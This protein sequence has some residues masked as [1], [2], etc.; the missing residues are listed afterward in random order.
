MHEEEGRCSD[1]KCHPGLR[2]HNL[3]DYFRFELVE[4]C[5]DKNLLANWDLIMRRRNKNNGGCD[6]PL[7]KFALFLVSVTILLFDCIQT[8]M[9]ILV[10][11]LMLI[12][13][14]LLLIIVLVVVI[15][16]HAPYFHYFHRKTPT[17]TSSH[18]LHV[19]LEVG[20]RAV[21]R[22]L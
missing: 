4:C 17:L 9:K 14:V 3:T 15:V 10:L 16:F 20:L 19:Q 22:S 1:F 21:P 11:L 12:I 18:A 6:S 7:D 8:P 13:L 2:I 5:Y